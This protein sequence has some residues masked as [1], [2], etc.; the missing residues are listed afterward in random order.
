MMHNMKPPYLLQQHIH[1]R[2]YIYSESLN[3]APPE[4]GQTPE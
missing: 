4:E 2:I 3:S 1:Y